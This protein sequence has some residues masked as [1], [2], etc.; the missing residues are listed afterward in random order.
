MPATYRIDPA[1]RVVWSHGWGVV[2][3]EE[4]AA[5]SRRLRDDPRFKPDFRQL[6]DLSD[7]DTMQVTV[8]GLAVVAKLNPFGA[9]AR[10]AVVVGTDVAYGLARAHEMLRGDPADSLVV[11]RDR[12]AALEWLGL[13]T[14][15]VPPQPSPDDPVF[16]SNRP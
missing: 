4:L 1:H 7:V 10:R 9:G 16:D 5:H 15:W 8:D 14:G 11:F 12:A 3:N 6:Q 2:T 13:P